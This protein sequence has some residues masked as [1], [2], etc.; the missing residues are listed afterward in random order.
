MTKRATWA[1]A[2]T[3]AALLL[4]ACRGLSE[5]QTPSDAG[6]EL[7]EQA[8]LEDAI[9]EFDE[10]IRLSPQD[11]EAYYNRGLSYG[12]LGQ[13]QR[14]IQDYDEAIRI[15]PRLAPAYLNRGTTYADLGQLQRAIEDYGEA[16]RLDSQLALAYLSR[17]DTYTEPWFSD[18]V[19]N[20][21]EWYTK[22]L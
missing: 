7:A 12:N 8:R 16:I 6:A 18:A 1:I 11:A 21:V 19:S 15:D 22:Y 2:L 9:P 17:G 13:H 4:A 20:M 10:A 14:A 3:L 5:T